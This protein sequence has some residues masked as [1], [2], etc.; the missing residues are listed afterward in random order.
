M[1]HYNF[2]H[3]HTNTGHCAWGCAL[4]SVTIC[5]LPHTLKDILIGP[6]PDICEQNLHQ[7]KNSSTAA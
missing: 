7:S 2:R 1:E 3:L 6:L 4:K 5:G